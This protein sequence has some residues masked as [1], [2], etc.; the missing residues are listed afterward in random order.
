MLDSR[1]RQRLHHA[2]HC[3]FEMEH[4][5]LEGEH[6]LLEDAH[7][8]LEL[9][10]TMVVGTIGASWRGLQGDDDLGAFLAPL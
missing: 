4:A 10:H 5:L 2:L 1:R 6:A 8:L 7:F 3:S 9:V